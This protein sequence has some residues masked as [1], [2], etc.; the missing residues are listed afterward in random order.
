MA[1]EFCETYHVSDTDPCPV[2]LAPQ[3]AP[4]G[5]QAYWGDADKKDYLMAIM[6][7]EHEG[8]PPVRT[9]ETPPGSGALD[10]EA[11]LG[12]PLAIA[13]VGEWV[14]LGAPAA[15]AETWPARFFG[16]IV[17][18]QNL[19][20]VVWQVMD[21]VMRVMRDKGRDWPLLG[22]HLLA[23]LAQAPMA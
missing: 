23:V 21:R 6:L 17:P 15:Y 10:Y 3:K 20:A 12:I 1:C 18:Q 2:C 19:E 7:D 4:R 5:L 13:L 22:D 9:P 11:S 14:W 8:F 16:T